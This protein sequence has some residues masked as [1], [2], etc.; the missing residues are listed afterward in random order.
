M[1]L[2]Q[3]FKLNS[4]MFHSIHKPNKRQ[5]VHFKTPNGAWTNHELIWIHK[6]QYG[7]DLGGSNTLFRIIYFAAPHK[8]YIEMAN[9]WKF[10]KLLNY[11]PNDFDG[12]LISHFTLNWKAL[13]KIFCNYW[14]EIYDD[15]SNFFALTLNTSFKRL[16]LFWQFDFK[17]FKLSFNYCYNSF[18]LRMWGQFVVIVFR[19]FWCSKE[20]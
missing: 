19:L 9:C 10:L 11:Q 8:S 6:T 2:R 3:V 12:S 5:L 13:K 20:G 17:P 1:G 15:T 16:K 7:L 14:K 4:W 18:F